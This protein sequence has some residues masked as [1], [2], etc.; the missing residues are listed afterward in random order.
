MFICIA[1]HPIKHFKCNQ[2]YQEHKKQYHSSSSRYICSNRNLQL[3]LR[4]AYYYHVKRKCPV[5]NMKISYIVIF[6]LEFFIMKTWSFVVICCLNVSNLVGLVEYMSSWIYKFLNLLFLLY[7]Q[8]I[9][10]A[11]T[12]ADLETVKRNIF[13]N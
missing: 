9:I 2:Y 13:S 8:Q 7:S 4:Y 10:W 12:E 6:L 1:C 5:G 11:I 3:Q